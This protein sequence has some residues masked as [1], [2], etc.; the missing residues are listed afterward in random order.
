MDIKWLTR[1]LALLPRQQRQATLLRN[2]SSYCDGHKPIAYILGHVPFM[3]SNQELKILCRPPILI[4]RWE[5]EEWVNTLI[6]SIFGLAQK[7]ETIL[8]ACTGSGAIG[9][10]L[11]KALGVHQTTLLDIDLRAIPLARRNCT[12]N[13]V[14]DSVALLVK[15]VLQIK[16]LSPFDMIVCNPPYIRPG[17]RLPHSVRQ[18]ESSTALFLHTHQ[19]IYKH[20]IDCRFHNQS[21]PSTDYPRIVFEIGCTEQAKQI[22]QWTRPYQRKCTV[23]KDTCKQTRCVYVY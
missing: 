15:D 7:P 19:S 18:W 16:D 6:Q 17:T 10:A 12:V 22:Q 23:F 21:V 13:G 8:D 1:D 11:S 4:P 9:I 3:A 14:A 20:L 5:T 2:I